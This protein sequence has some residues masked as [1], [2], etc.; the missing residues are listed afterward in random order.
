MLDKLTNHTQGILDRYKQ[1]QPKFIFAETEA[2]YGGKTINLLPKI[3]AVAKDLV[4]V[5]VQRVIL[6]DGIVSGKEPSSSAL[7]K[8][9]KR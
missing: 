9:P 3:E 7:D 6:L 5:G 8:I 4:H 1:I 2:V